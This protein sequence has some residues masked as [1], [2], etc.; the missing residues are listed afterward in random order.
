MLWITPLQISYPISYLISP[1]YCLKTYKFNYTDY[2]IYVEH[3]LNLFKDWTIIIVALQHEGILWQLTMKSN[4]D[5]DYVGLLSR[6]KFVIATKETR[7]GNVTYIQG[8]FI[9]EVV[10]VIIGVYKVYTGDILLCCCD[11]F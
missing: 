5:I 10:N 3:H 1:V 2:R 9:T 7:Y 11:T 8:V 6:Q 4:I